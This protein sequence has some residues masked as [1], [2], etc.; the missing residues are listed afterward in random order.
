M[1]MIPGPS[2]GM[3]YLNP[4]M[5]MNGWWQN[6]WPSYPYGFQAHVCSRRSN[7]GGG[8]MGPMGPMGPMGRTGPMGA[9]E[10]LD[11]PHLLKF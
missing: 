7:D 2:G 4:P 8:M 1:G 10:R 11:S 5:P 9:E 3:G 6:V